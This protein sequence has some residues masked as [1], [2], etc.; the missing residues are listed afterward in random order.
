MKRP[1]RAMVRTIAAAALVAVASISCPNPIDDDL[2]L[3]VDDATPP[4]IQVV[5]P[6][7]NSLYRYAVDVSGTIRDFSGATGT[8]PGYVR[9]LAFAA[10]GNPSLARTVTIEHDGTFSVVPPDPTFDYDPASGAFSLTVDT[11]GLTGMQFL[12][13]SRT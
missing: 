3:V 2:L 5:S 1:M 6:A 4:V 12:T 9:R 11:V 13:C 7:Q 10:T 8:E